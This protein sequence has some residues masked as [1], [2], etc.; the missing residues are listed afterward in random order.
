MLDDA[1]VLRENVKLGGGAQFWG[2][3][4]GM[5]NT[6]E[7]VTHFRIILEHTTSD[8]LG[9]ITDEDYTVGMIQTPNLFGEFKVTVYATGTTFAEKKLDLLDDPTIW[10]NPNIFCDSNNAGMIGIVATEDGKSA[11]YWTI[12]NAYKKP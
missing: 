2:Y 9:C 3:L 5:F 7:L 6:P 8:W 4:S 11:K 12:S 1:L 10:H